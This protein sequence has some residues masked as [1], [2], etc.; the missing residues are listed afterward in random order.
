MCPYRGYVFLVGRAVGGKG[1]RVTLLSRLV[2]SKHYFPCFLG[3][4]LQAQ[5]LTW[6]NSLP[7]GLT[8]ANWK[9]SFTSMRTNWH[10]LSRNVRKET[11][12]T[13]TTRF[14]HGRCISHA[15]VFN[16]FLVSSWTCLQGFFFPFSFNTNIYT[17]T[18]TESYVIS[19]ICRQTDAHTIQHWKYQVH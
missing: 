5:C 11:S 9:R 7:F 4:S 1:W 8:L 19:S 2:D 12:N 3:S 6:L 17:Q 10:I 14:F 16:C 15:L 13:G 18:D